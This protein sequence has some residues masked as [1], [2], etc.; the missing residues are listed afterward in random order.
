MPPKKPT[1]TPA[2]LS[3]VPAQTV[4]Q[5]FSANPDAPAYYASSFALLAS[6]QDFVIVVGQ[7]DTT[8][9]GAQMKKIA[10][11]FV[12]PVHTKVLARALAQ[13]VTEYEAEYGEILDITTLVGPA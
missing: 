4:I 11:I 2:A 9:E 7:L 10:T 3:Q 6:P 8:P 1:K 13:K 12:S 5:A